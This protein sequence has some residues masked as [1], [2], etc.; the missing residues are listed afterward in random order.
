MRLL[1]ARGA[2]PAATN[3]LKHMLSRSRGP[4]D[5]A[6]FSQPVPIPT[7]QTDAAKPPSLG[8]LAWTPSTPVIAALLDAAVDIDAR[9]KD[10]RTAYSLAVLGVRTETIEHLKSR[11]ADTRLSPLDQF[12]QSCA[13]ATP[14]ELDRIL[15]TRPD[16]S[17]VPNSGRLLADVAASHSTQAVRAL[18]A[19]GVPIDSRGEL[20][21]TALH[22]ACWKG[23]AD[24]VKLLLDHGAPLAIEDEQFHATPSGWFSHGV[25]NCDERQGN[26]PE[27]AR[28]LIAAKAKFG[29]TDLPTNNAEVDAVFRAHGL[30]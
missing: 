20:G 26:Y 23:H 3:A 29:P 21:A 6:C 8:H 15:A 9:R 16:F 10:G 27:V 7:R 17:S 11:G 19:A 28:L 2:K 24:I 4:R 5:S 30:T 12:V 13:Q 1:L 25:Q 14:A 18:L 22:W